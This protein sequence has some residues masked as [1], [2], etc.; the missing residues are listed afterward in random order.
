M[1]TS[2]SG[3]RKVGRGRAGLPHVLADGRADQRLAVLEQDQVAAGSE[4]AVL[5]EDAV[6]R[7]EALAV[8]RLHLPAREDETGVEEVA[9]E[10]GRAHEHGRAAC[11]TRDLL[12]AALGG[13]HEAGTQQQVLRRI[14]GDR[15]LREE[16]EIGSVRFRVGEVAENHVAV[17]LEVSDDRVDLGKGEAHSLSLAVSASESKT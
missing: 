8:D 10:V 13:A 6:V 2:S 12:D 1:L 15:K 11:L 14:A 7:Q 3:E 16:D 5:V 17:A 4:V 9:V